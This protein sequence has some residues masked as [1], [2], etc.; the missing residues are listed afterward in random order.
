MA[1]ASR[2]RPRR[3]GDIGDRDR[4][5]ERSAG[6]APRRVR[7]TRRTD[8][9]PR[10]RIVHSSHCQNPHPR[11]NAPSDRSR[12]STPNAFATG[13]CP[14]RSR[15]SRRVDSGDRGAQ[16]PPRGFLSIVSHPETPGP[17]RRSVAP[18]LAALRHRQRQRWSPRAPPTWVRPAL[19]GE[20]WTVSELDRT[21]CQTVAGGLRKKT[22]SVATGL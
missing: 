8:P 18:G 9:P 10:R 14:G 15:R 16:T 22:M 3:R 17:S 1:G 5:P 12:F 20:S 21:G 13:G 4:G 19:R 7:R 11:V 6:R 2:W